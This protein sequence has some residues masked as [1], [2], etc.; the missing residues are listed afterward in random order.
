MKLLLDDHKQV[1]VWVDDFNEDDKLSPWF[2]YEED[3]LQWADRV[4]IELDKMGNKQ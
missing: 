1:Y 4:K 2:D 3:A